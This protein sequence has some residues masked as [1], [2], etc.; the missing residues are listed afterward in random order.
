MADKPQTSYEEI[1]SG[2][3]NLSDYEP[4]NNWILVGIWMRPEKTASGIYL[5]DKTRDEDKWQGKAGYVLAK[6]PTAFVSDGT[7]DFHDQDVSPGECIVYRVSD[8]YSMDINGVHCR[9]LQD[10]DIKMR[11]KSPASIY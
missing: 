2:I 7:V 10:T 4:M 1:L 3:G 6:G 9:M 11:I 8:G 5:S